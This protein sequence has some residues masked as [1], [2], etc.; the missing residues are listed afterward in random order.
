ME[1]GKKESVREHVDQLFA[2]ARC[3][4]TD[5]LGG[6]Y[7]ATLNYPVCLDAAIFRSRQDQVQY[8]GSKDACGRIQKNIGDTHITGA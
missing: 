1:V 6:A 7:P 8:L 4:T 3:Q 5:R 2:L